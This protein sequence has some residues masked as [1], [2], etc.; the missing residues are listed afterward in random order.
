MGRWVRLAATPFVAAFLLAGMALSP[1]P[2]WGAP[3]RPAS[4]PLSSPAHNSRHTN[5]SAVL[6]RLKDSSDGAPLVAA[7]GD[8]ACDPKNP[9]FAGGNGDKRACRQKQTSKLLRPA[10]AVLALGD[11]QYENGAYDKYMK[12]YDKTWGRYKAKTHPAIGNHEYISGTT[13]YARYFG[14]AARGPGGT[15]FYYSYDIDDWHFIVLNS[16]C[17]RLPRGKGS[18]G[19]AEGSPQNM[20]LERDLAAHDEECSVVYAHHSRFPAGND[21]GIEQMADMWTDLYRA[22]VDV[23]L[24]GH[25]HSY[26][27]FARRDAKGDFADEGIRQFAVG[28]GGVNLA[29]FKAHRWTRTMNY[30]DFG[31][32]YLT[33]RDGGYNWKYVSIWG[34][35][36]DGGRAPC[37]EADDDDRA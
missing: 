25:G 21:K 17:E 7:A 37:H 35:Y 31:V 19:C 23:Y 28:T 5:P 15:P 32:L 8:I 20:W 13:G 33:L 22:R 24:N 18:N 6:Q 10:D 34:T 9:R 36:S 26:E 11:T 30:S 1:L 14:A 29:H 16:N 2:G 12:S 3:S 27:R 4:S